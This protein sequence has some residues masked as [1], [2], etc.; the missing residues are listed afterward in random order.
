MPN[1]TARKVPATTTGLISILCAPALF[2]MF[3]SAVMAQS[4]LEEI[5][6][7]ATKREQSLGDIS[8]AVSA[9]D[10]ERL[11]T[12]QINDVGDLQIIAPYITFGEAYDSARIFIRGVGTN[13]E[14]P[15]S[16]AGVAVYTDGAPIGRQEAHLMSF[17]DLERI[18]VLRGP[19][20]T[21]YGRNAVG[22]AINYITA[23]PT[24]EFEGYARASYG[25]YDYLELSAA[26][27]GPIN[28]W[29]KARVAYKSLNR[30]GFG[31]NIVT[32]S[33]VDDA[34]RQMARLSIILEPTDDLSI[35]LSGE[36]YEQ[37]DA[38]GIIH[39]D[40]GSTYNAATGQQDAINTR[41]VQGAIFDP[42]TGAYIVVPEG[43]G[44]WASDPRDTAEPID[45]FTKRDRWS[46][47]GQ[48]D[49][50]VNDWLTV[51][52][53]TNV[54]NLVSVTSQYQAKSSFFQ[55]RHT[56]PLTRRIGNEPQ[57]STELQF[58]MKN[59]WAQGILGFM[60]YTE[61][62]TENQ[63][64]GSDG[65]YSIIRD[66]VG[67]AISN[68]LLA[69]GSSPEALL[70]FCGGWGR[71]VLDNPGLPNYPPQICGRGTQDIEA[72][73]IY[74]NTTIDLGKFSDGLSDFAL[75][76]GARYSHDQRTVSNPFYFIGI[77]QANFDANPVAA[78]VTALVLVPPTAVTNDA[79]FTDFSPEVGLEWRPTSDY[80]FYYT[81]SE[82]FKAG[83]GLTV[84]GATQLVDP[85]HITNHEFG[86]KGTFFDGKLQ[87]AL[88]GF[89]NTLKDAQYQRST[90]GPIAGFITQLENA[91]EIQAKGVELEFQSLLYESEEANIRL[92][93]HLAYLDSEFSDFTTVDPNDPVIRTS[94]LPA[95]QLIQD[96]SGNATRNAPKWA[97]TARTEI[98][99]PA[100]SATLPGEGMLT[101][102][103]D[104]NY[105]SRT[106]LTEYNNIYESAKP[107][108]V[109]NAELTYRTAGGI[110]LSAWG[111]NLTDKF[112]RSASVFLNAVG[113][114]EV[115]YFPPRTYGVTVGYD[116]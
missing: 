105:R 66:D 65:A 95:A 84:P 52:S 73:G 100:F 3:Q 58:K 80:L 46:V 60:Y 27:G 24:D 50:D 34:D 87:V 26:V 68:Y 93:T 101:L 90:P 18:E 40:G 35:L 69:N 99:F 81:Y 92:D 6:V 10:R 38:A 94:P 76:L 13:V 4:R 79:T 109:F 107:R 7:T 59:D 54:Q 103:G 97:L 47:T 19:Q 36:W 57:A 111:K 102:S 49:W 63:T 37:N 112:F 17:F 108:T 67:T 116:F 106:Y 75:K 42:A 89:T 85:E 55:L 56:S 61:R 20:G 78:N 33:D 8:A 51:T 110:T 21:L 22:G 71:K 115:T 31:E 2:I 29:I 32:G 48:I 41:D 5:V 88:S 30:G 16:S 82:G 11:R 91:A 98:D 72:Y 70:R 64:L 44:G 1:K 83:T 104:I 114:R 74:A 9:Y 14:N 28:D 23:K 53:I 113:Q 25:N 15:G 39:L 62:Q 45:P 12:S 77:D 86:F 43:R 96:L